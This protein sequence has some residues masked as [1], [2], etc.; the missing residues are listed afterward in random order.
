MAAD[1]H[2]QIGY[3]AQGNAIITGDHGRA[4]VFPGITEL[5]T[6]GAARPA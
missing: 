4:Y 5:F 2:V 1:R 6:P 3:D